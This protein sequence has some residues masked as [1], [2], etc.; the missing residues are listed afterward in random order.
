MELPRHLAIHWAPP[1]IVCDGTG[2]LDVL[3]SE[4]DHVAAGRDAVAKARG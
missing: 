3:M 1:R 4:A 2:G